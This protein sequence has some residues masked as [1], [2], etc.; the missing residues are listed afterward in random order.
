MATAQGPSLA[1]Q[2]GQPT[3]AS[4]RARLD[5][6]RAAL[7]RDGAPDYRRR[8]EALGALLHGVLARKDDF[9]RAASEDFGGRA[10][11]ETLALELLPLVDQI[12]HARRHLRSWIEPR[13][14]RTGWQFWPA[15]SLVVVQPLGVVGII[16]AWNYPIYLSLAPLADALA[17]GNHALVKPSE[18]APRTAELLREMIA[19]VLPEDYVSV[20]NGGP[21]VSA[22]FASLPFDHLLFTGS[23]RVGRL[24]MRAASEN[25]TP[26]TLELGGKS[27]AIVHREYP[28]KR[29]AERI[30][31]GKLYNAG[32]TCIAPDYLLLPTEHRD[33]FLRLANQIVPQLYP[34]LVENP[35]YTRIINRHHYER[36]AGLVEDARRRGA[37]VVEINPAGETCNAENRV[38]PPTLVT[39][40][41]PGMTVMQEEIFG[42]ILPVVTYRTLDEAI[43]YINGRP[44]PLSLYYFDE[45]SARVN[46]M[47]SRTIS[48]GVTVN[49]VIF[50]IAQHNLPFGGVGPSGMGHYHGFDGF[51]TFSKKKGVFLQSR[52]TGLSWLR[53]PYGPRARRLIRFL[54]S[55]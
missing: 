21:E 12:R 15:R 23:T 2:G 46:D 18:L 9:V 54:L 11:E 33:A 41:A 36:L 20:V 42:P 13:R 48:G 44:R 31:T 34:R 7:G 29:A 53:P 49:D 3:A 55:R 8:M 4:L 38:F 39:D 32:Q 27:P 52:F 35:D 45:D 37:N 5:H 19:A 40:P 10:P 22:A 1:V 43:A 14:V 51:E 6:Q 17:A 28:L 25:L 16:A 50:H 47:L 26:V 24:V 30:L